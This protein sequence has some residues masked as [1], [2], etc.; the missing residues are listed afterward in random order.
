MSI[1]KTDPFL[2]LYDIFFLFLSPINLYNIILYYLF[3][4]SPAVLKKKTKILDIF[5]TDKKCFMEIN[6]ESSPPEIWIRIRFL[7]INGSPSLIV[8]ALIGKI[9]LTQFR[10]QGIKLKD[11]LRHFVKYSEWLY[12]PPSLL[13]NSNN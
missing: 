12:L 10:L 11:I 9:T 5:Y 1:A 2:F 6:I 3:E 8:I 13:C 4:Y 7:E